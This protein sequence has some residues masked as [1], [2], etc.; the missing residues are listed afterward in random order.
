MKQHLLQGWRLALKHLPVIIVLFLYQLLWGFFLYRAVQS[1]VLPL[2]KRYPDAMNDS[3][4]VQLFLLEAQFR[5]TKTE[6][7]EPYLWLLG[8]LLAARMLLTPFIQAGLAYSLHHTQDSRGTHFLRGIRLA[9][10]PML[11]LYA[12]EMALLLAPAWWLLPIASRLLHTS[13]S[14]ELLLLNA[15]PYLCGWLAWGGLL[16]LLFRAVQFGVIARCGWFTSA[17][18]ALRSL[19]PLVGISLVLLGASLLLSLTASAI[20]MIWTGL[21]AFI[22]HQ[23]FY[24]VRSLFKV[25]TMASQYH[26]WQ[27]RQIAEK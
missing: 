3:S 2:L 14:G 16:H 11:A 7:I 9:W 15:S 1:V 19:L 4:S 18:A 24:L 21:L 10:K 17:A 26:V 5:L 22:L 23:A 27:E 6:L 8:G 12:A 20:S 25:W 13:G